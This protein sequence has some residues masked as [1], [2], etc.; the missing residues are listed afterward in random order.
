MICIKKP[1]SVFRTGAKGEWE[2][3]KRR[4]GFEK[5][6][7]ETGHGTGV[8]GHLSEPGQACVLLTDHT[9]MAMCH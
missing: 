4:W 3:L 8:G 1:E 2:S 6:E 5:G 9:N 7:W